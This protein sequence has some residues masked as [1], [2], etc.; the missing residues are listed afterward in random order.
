M[1]SDYSFTKLD[2]WFSFFLLFFSPLSYIVRYCICD[3]SEID[4]KGGHVAKK[5]SS[6]GLLVILI[7]SII[8]VHVLKTIILNS[9]Q[10]LEL[11]LNMTL[12][13]KMQ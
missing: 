8:Y 7:F 9:E 12:A 10:L 1:A 13:N 5:V 11:T 4:V 6:M 3:F 2:F